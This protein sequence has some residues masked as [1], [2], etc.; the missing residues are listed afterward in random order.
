M[1][2]IKHLFLKP[3]PKLVPFITAGYPKIDSTVELVISAENAGA[4]MVEIG[5]PY[6]DPLADGPVIQASSQRALKNGITLEKI[7]EQVSTIRRDSSIP[8]ALMG[9]FNPILRM[10]EEKFLDRCVK[11]G[12]DGLILPDLPL[13]EAGE[14]CAQCKFR[15]LSPILLVAPNT[16]ETRIRLISEMAGDLIYA[17]SILGVT[18][19]GLGSKKSLK[20]YLQRVRDNSSTPFIVGFGI[21]NQQDVKFFNQYADGAIVGTAIIEKLNGGPEDSKILKNYLRELKGK[22]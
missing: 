3:G 18:G 16:T 12:V 6:S 13:D 4:D 8:I 1:N 21:R 10:G 20:S 5:I 9:Y 11:T 14:F 15:G 22:V 17:V 2:R 7:F 19:D